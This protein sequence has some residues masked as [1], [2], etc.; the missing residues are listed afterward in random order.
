[1]YLHRIS[2]I[3]VHFVCFQRCKVPQTS[4][5]T[6][7]ELSQND[8]K[9]FQAET[10]DGLDLCIGRIMLHCQ[11]LALCGPASINPVTM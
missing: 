1:M 4:H 8:P 9:S 11:I 5:L 3:L 2:F 6:S 10:H 7:E